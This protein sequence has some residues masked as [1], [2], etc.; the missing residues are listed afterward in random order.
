MSKGGGAGRSGKEYD[1]SRPLTTGQVARVC[2]VSPVTVRKWVDA[3]KLEACKLHSGHRRITPDAFRA[4]VERHSIPISG[5][6]QMPPNSPSPKR[7]YSGPPKLERSYC[8]PALA[9][10]GQIVVH[11]E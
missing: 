1:F 2:R 3:G 10:G 11:K 7:C 8:P 9:S 6:W 5:E 4:F